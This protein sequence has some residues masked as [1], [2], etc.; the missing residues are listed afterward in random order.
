MYTM[1]PEILQYKYLLFLIYF[2]VFYEKKN[3]IK[4]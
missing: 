1:S 2:Y 3:E 4:Y